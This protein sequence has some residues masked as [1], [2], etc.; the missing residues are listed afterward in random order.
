MPAMGHGTSLVPTVTSQ[1]DG[2]YIADNIDFFMPASW[3]LRITFSAE[4][5]DGSAGATDSAT[6]A[7]DIP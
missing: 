5:S 1:Q 7:F 2:V 6:P 4:H 3:Q